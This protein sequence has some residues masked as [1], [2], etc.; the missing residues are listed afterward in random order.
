MVQALENLAK[1]MISADRVQGIDEKVVKVIDD[2]LVGAVSTITT[3][4]LEP[5]KVLVS[6]LSGKVAVSDKSINDLAL[7]NNVVHKSGAEIVNGQKT[8]TSYVVTQASVPRFMSIF[9]NTE[10]GTKPTNSLTASFAA[11]TAIADTK[12]R[13]ASVDLSYKNDGSTQASL[14]AYKPQ[15]DTVITSSITVTYPETGEPYTSVPTPVLSSTDSHYKNQ[16]VNVGYLDNKVSNVVH[17]TDNE[18]ITGVKTISI[19]GSDANDSLIIKNPISVADAIPTTSNG[20]FISFKDKNN[21]TEG[22]LE[23]YH[24]ETGTRYAALNVCKEGRSA[25]QIAI[26]FDSNNKI[27]TKAPTPEANDSSDKIATTAFVKNILSSLYPVGSIY[28]GTQSTCPLTSLIG[29]SSWSKVGSGRVLW[30][31]DNNHAANT[32]IEAGLPNITGTF[33]DGDEY[34]NTNS[35]DGAFYRSNVGG[36]TTWDGNSSPKRA[37][38]DASRSSPIYGRSST[39]Q[40]PAYV[41]NIWRRTA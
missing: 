15:L 26:G 41:V 5:N 29:G 23:F 20:R 22:Y 18:T 8:F 13:L 34:G 32:T 27:Y 12:Y 19:S 17:T 35:L 10:K 14:S 33:Q 31:S 6:N 24:S 7:D 4:D 25:N 11:K 28:I 39:V 38:F 16:I 3:S 36:H 40:P 9:P 1:S 2:T 30:G 37:G 21:V